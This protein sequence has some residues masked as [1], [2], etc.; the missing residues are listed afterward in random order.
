MELLV[1]SE[2]FLAERDKLNDPLDSSFTMSLESYLDIYYKKYPSLKNEKHEKLLK[3]LY[4][5]HSEQGDKKF[6]SELSDLPDSQRI[7]CF[8]ED[9]NNPLMW[10]H[11]TANHNGVCLKFDLSKDEAFSNAIQPVN[12][13]DELIDVRTTEDFQK[14]LLTKLSP[15]K[16][17]K[18]WR[19]L[20]K[21]EKFPFKEEALIEIVLGLNVPTSTFVWLSKMCE[22]VYFTY[23]KIHKLTI[24][25][26]RLVKVN[27]YEDIVENNFIPM[28]N[29]DAY[30]KESDF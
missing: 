10:S 30:P 5:W 27:K 7:T 15:W 28:I 3:F 1:N 22:N 8:T 14:S 19:I 21:N 24:R 9:G 18:E 16:I 11:Y 17:E 23:V 4:Q 12:Y 25:A 6:L 13:I 29:D 2:F 26:N 20:D